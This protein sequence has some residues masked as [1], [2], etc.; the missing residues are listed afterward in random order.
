[1]KKLVIRWGCSLAFL[2]LL[3]GHAAGYY[4][5]LFVDS[6]DNLIYDA[7]LR[8][9]MPGTPDDRIVIVDIDEKSL[10][11]VGRWPW[12]RDRMAELVDKLF[13]RDGVAMVG[14]DVVMAEPDRSSGLA[15]LDALAHGALR[16]DVSYLATL[17][18]LRGQ[19]DYDMRFAAALDEKPV[20]LGYYLANNAQPSGVLPAPVLRASTGAARTAGLI[21]WASYGGNLAAFQQAAMDAGFF[22]SVVDFDG[23]VRRVAM[24][25]TQQGNTYQSLSLAMVRTLLG[26][27]DVVP[28]FGGPGNGHAMGEGGPALEA[29]DLH[30]PRGVIHIPVDE[31]GAALVP[32]RGYQHSFRYVSASDVLADRVPR[33]QLQGRIVLVGTT[34]PGLLD[35]RSTPVGRAYPGVEIHANLISGMLDGTIKHAPG[36]TNAAQVM[37]LLLAGGLMI[38]F[39]PWRS[40][41]RA[42]IASVLLLATVIAGDFAL[43]QYA[44]WV[45]PLAASALLIIGLF[46]LN[47]SLGYFVESRAKRQFA[48]LFGQYVP[49][50]LV[51]EMSRQPESY[52]MQGRR[53]ELTVLFSDVRGFTTISEAL[54]PEQLAE[55]M[56]DYLDTMTAVIRAQRGTLDK[57]IGD[58]IM[59]FWGAPVAD[60]RHAQNAVLASLRMQAAL[61]ELNRR[62]GERG[63]AV[64][65]IGIGVNTGP[66]TVGDMGSAV[67]KAYT[68][69][70]DA[71]NLGARLEGV[72]K[73]YGVGIVVGE[74]T[75]AL[76]H[77]IA[78]RELD[79]VKVKGKQE[80]VAIFEPLGEQASL[81]PQLRE[82]TERWHEAL[83]CYR[84]RD[85]DAAATRLS[86]LAEA[87][88]DCRLYAL[89]LDRIAQLRTDAPGPEWDGVYTFDTK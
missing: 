72:T 21:D 80:P 41:W 20:V 84:A 23:N 75:Q 83:A 87:C 25:A 15:S 69:M 68:V 19:L 38:F 55:L 10:A 79:R 64:I 52:S 65:E 71:V 60:A 22:N 2:L 73:H 40:P 59:A 85:W 43:W 9:T 81:S 48:D 13:G 47:M 61:P 70:G 76:T 88:P 36:Y 7:R 31:H 39:F 57:Y 27:P 32:Y 3:L 14:F 24:L 37:A 4:R 51:Q 89:Y 50:E 63:W 78:Y 16:H 18:G 26:R 34:A 58:A 67:R 28:N 35:L 11:Q 56:N 82:E 8:L 17:N 30:T 66:M 53:A 29:V 62:F 6:L 42:T 86:A 33:S 46:G 77:G 49:P 44:N 1:L 74:A 45:L 12:G 5:L 54:E